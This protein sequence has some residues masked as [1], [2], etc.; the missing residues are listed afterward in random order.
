[1]NMPELIENEPQVNETQ[2]VKMNNLSDKQTC[3]QID[4]Q[5]PQD[6]KQSRAGDQHTGHQENVSQDYSQRQGQEIRLLQ[7]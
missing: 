7:E 6:R 3:F 4:P 1:M 2:Q 5:M